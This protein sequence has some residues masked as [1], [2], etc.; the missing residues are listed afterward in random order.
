LGAF[1]NSRPD[2]SEKS[3]ENSSLPVEA[4]QALKAWI[5]AKHSLN[6]VMLREDFQSLVRPIYLIGILSRHYMLLSVPPGNRL[7]E[8]VKH[9]SPA[10]RAAIVKHDY[11][12]AGLTPYPNDAALLQLR[13]NPSF[14]PFVELIWHK[15]LENI[16]ARQ[17]SENARDSAMLEVCL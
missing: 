10:I 2:S 15:R 4:R 6:R 12:L 1:H 14:A 7:V 8:R 11:D 13:E 3:A 16:A 17:A 9:F 5:G